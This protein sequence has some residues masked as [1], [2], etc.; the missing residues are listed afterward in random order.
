MLREI[1]YQETWVFSIQLL[2]YLAL[3]ASMIPP[4]VACGVK[5]NTRVVKGTRVQGLVYLGLESACA[6]QN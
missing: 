1:G 6:E 5:T 2:D 3:V 4:Q